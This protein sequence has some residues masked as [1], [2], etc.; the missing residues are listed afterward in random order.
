MFRCNHAKENKCQW[1]H[2]KFI[3]LSKYLSHL[4]P[5]RNYEM[6]LC[7]I[8]N[9]VGKSAKLKLMTRNPPIMHKDSFTV[10]IL[11]ITIRLSTF[12]HLCTNQKKV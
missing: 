9:I 11:T 3:K 12:M 1:C 6:K 8:S 2:Q 4:A 7:E 5:V 10:K